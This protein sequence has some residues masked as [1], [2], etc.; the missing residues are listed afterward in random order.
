M[1]FL[2][3]VEISLREISFIFGFYINM[4]FIQHLKSIIILPLQCNFASKCVNL[5]VDLIEPIK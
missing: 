2:V 3:L 5:S 4:Y 1:I